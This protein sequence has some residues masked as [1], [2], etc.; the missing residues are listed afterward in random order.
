MARDVLVFGLILLL[1]LGSLGLLA[2]AL[3]L[4]NFIL[5]MITLLILAALY[6]AW[7]TDVIIELKEYER[8]VIFRFGKYVGT[9]GPG[10]IVLL[11]FIEEYKVVDLRVQTLDVPKQEV[12]TGDNV[13][14]VIDAVIYLRVVDPAKAVLRVDDY[15]QAS[16]LFVQ[17]MIRDLVGGMTL[18]EVINNIEELNKKIQ[19]ELTKMAQ[20]WGVKVV[21][22][23]IKTVEIPERVKHAMHDMMVAEKEKIAMTHKAEATKIELEAIKEATKDMN[24][25][26]L[27]YFYLEALKKLAEG[28]A[29]KI[30]YPLDFSTLAQAISRQIGGV[31]PPDKVEADLKKYGDIIKKVLES[32]K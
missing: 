17:S 16:V 4:R 23:Q 14:L 20:D 11:P 3:S 28:R 7:K 8:A 29:T 10:W 2:Y 24:E 25:R 1:L 6:I 26:V 19:A 31:V 5:A 27:L 32:Q 15:K 21:S 12:V 18:E 30:I 13:V 9:R 22:V